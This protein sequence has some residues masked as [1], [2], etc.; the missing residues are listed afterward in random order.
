[1]VIF[2]WRKSIRKSKHLKRT[3]DNEEVNL[4]KKT[5]NTFHV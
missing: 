4:R 5:Y 1:M 2:Q 3:Y